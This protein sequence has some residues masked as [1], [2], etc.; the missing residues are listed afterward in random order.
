MDAAWHIIQDGLF[1]AIAAVGFAAISNPPRQAFKWCALIAAVG[2]A[3]RYVMMTYVGLGIV[4]ASLL[5]AIGIGLLATLIAPRVKC[6]P[7]T[8]SYP[9]LLPMIPGMYAYRCLQSFILLLNAHGQADYSYYAYH[10]I[11]NGTI[12]LFVIL[13]MVIGQWAPI[14]LLNRISFS[15]TRR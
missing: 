1:A 13:A 2:H 11:S 6:P 7:E 9:S 5:G 3:T 15:S 12:T 4:G 10:C 8:F 14:L